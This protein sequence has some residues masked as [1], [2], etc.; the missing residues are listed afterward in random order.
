MTVFSTLLG[1]ALV[2]A[3]ALVAAPSA[4]AQININIG[5]P[6]HA[7]RVVVVRHAPK[8]KAYHPKKAK[9]GQAVYLVPSGP[10]YYQV[11]G[12]GHGKGKH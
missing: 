3:I 2:G 7:P 8:Y 12:K 5:Q 11:R 4:Q 6:A 9:K 10:A 1:T